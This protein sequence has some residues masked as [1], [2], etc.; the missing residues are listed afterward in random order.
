VEG[1]DLGRG[2]RGHVNH[3][4][5]PKAKKEGID[6]TKGR[7][8]HSGDYRKNES[9]WAWGCPIIQNQF[10]PMTVNQGKLKKGRRRRGPF[11]GV[12]IKRKSLSLLGR[13]EKFQA[14]W[15]D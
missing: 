10:Y 5:P 14:A 1:E 6:G 2:A 9:P 15:G 4:R 12:A 8:Y 3:G 11:E 7:V 13:D